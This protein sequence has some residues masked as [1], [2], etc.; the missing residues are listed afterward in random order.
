L[1]DVFSG[2]YFSSR[3]AE[4]NKS[5]CG[6]RVPGGCEK[7]IQGDEFGAAPLMRGSHVDDFHRV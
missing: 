1:H 7:K 6:V 3:V 4:K 5:G 2:Y